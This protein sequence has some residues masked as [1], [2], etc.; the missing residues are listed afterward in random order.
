MHAFKLELCRLQ[1]ARQVN[2]FISRKINAWE[3][4]CSESVWTWKHI[5]PL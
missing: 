5:K 1:E 4:L 2:I 3:K